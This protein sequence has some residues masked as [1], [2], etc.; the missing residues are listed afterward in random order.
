MADNLQ[1]VL[2]RIADIEARI[3]DASDRPATAGAHVGGAFRRTLAEVSG[4]PARG[5]DRYADI[6]A[7]AAQQ[8]GLRPAL[9]RAVITAESHFNPHAVSRAGAMGLMQLMPGTA[10]GL[11]VTN[12]FD[13]EQN[14]FGGARYLRAQLDR[15]D[16]D[17][18]LALAAYN[19]GP[20]A[21]KR[22]HGIPPFSET[23]HYVTRVLSLANSEE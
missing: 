20:G 4:A 7:R 13:P 18:R 21:V 11:G 22:Y 1:R 23:Q 5:D 16:G 15:F 14:I 17:E 10:A 3:G 6:I 12:P 8:F 9:L 2:R 19:A